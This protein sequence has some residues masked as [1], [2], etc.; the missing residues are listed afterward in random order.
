[1]N[2]SGKGSRLLGLIVSFALADKLSVNL[3]VG[4]AIKLHI[5]PTEN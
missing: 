4:I 5:F 2:Q 1:M 3:P